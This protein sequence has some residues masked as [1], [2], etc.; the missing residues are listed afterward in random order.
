MNN[1]LQKFSTGTLVY[2]LFF[3]QIRFGKILSAHP[4]VKDNSFGWYYTIQCGK[5]KQI[6]T[7]QA[8][9]W[10]LA[11]KHPMELLDRYVKYAKD[12]Y[13]EDPQESS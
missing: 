8:W 9:E 10:D 2:I 12:F 6:H 5:G 1:E 13:K 11:E 7:I 3:S 4:K